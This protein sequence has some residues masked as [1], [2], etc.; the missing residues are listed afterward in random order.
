MSPESRARRLLDERA[1]RLGP[2]LRLSYREPLEII[3]GEG[4]YLVARDGRR[5]LDLVNNVC[6]VGHCHPR[7]V[8]ALA[9]QAARLNTNTR[10]LHETVVEY[11]RRL[12][13]LLPDPLEVC[14]FVCSG[15]EANDL[16]LRLARAATGR[17]GVV[18]LEGAYHGNLGS[19]V[20]ISHYKFAGPGGFE[21]PPHVEVAPAPDVYRGRYRDGAEPARRYAGDVTVATARIAERGQPAAGFICESLLGCGGQV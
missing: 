4:A 9:A 2:S 6:H 8:E 13:D 12:T 14:Y 16:A 7:V 17:R 3:R 1:R 20:E 11:A 5:F 18:A 15:S 10:Y 21:C 19:L